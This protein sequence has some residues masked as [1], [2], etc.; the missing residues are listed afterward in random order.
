MLF[1]RSLPR[2]KDGFAT[3]I[4]FL[5][6]RGMLSKKRCHDKASD[7][8]AIGNV[9]NRALLALVAPH[10]VEESGLMPNRSRKP[11]NLMEATYLFLT[12]RPALHDL[13]VW[14]HF[15]YNVGCGTDDQV[16]VFILWF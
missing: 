7:W 4:R 16:F 1:E 11:A 5:T 13:R 9:Q 15:A 10:Y 8:P 2:W 12:H 6:Q 3:F 14:L